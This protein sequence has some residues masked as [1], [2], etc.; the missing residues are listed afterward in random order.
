MHSADCWHIWIDTGGTFTDCLALDPGGALH[1]AKVLSTS[2]LRGRI[3]GAVN[4]RTLRIEQNWNACDDAVKGCTFRLL[5]LGQ[6]ANSAMTVNRFDA[7]RSV[8]EL[9]GPRQESWMQSQA[10][11]EVQSAEPGGP[12]GDRHARTPAAAADLHAVGLHA[13]HQ[14]APATQRRTSGAV[15][16]RGF[17]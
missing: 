9:D 15:R 1:R 7:A 3:V 2:A 12:P 4:D 14:R 5:S 6:P 8:I 11:F 13:R 17:R 10:A 16:D